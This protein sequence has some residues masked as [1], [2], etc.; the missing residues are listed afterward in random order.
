MDLWGCQLILPPSSCCAQALADS[1]Q[2]V[3]AQIDVYQTAVR[4]MGEEQ[5]DVVRRNGAELESGGATCEL[6]FLDSRR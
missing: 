2:G 6:A 4:T 1:L 3:H 5:I